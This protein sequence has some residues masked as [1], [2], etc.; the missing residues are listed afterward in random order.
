MSPRTVTIVLP[1][2][3]NDAEEFASDCGFQLASVERVVAAAETVLKTFETDE[4]QGFR[5]RDRQY[6]I[7]I[8]RAALSPS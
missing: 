8:L 7:T 1:E 6:A 3:Y 5:S 2:G 4:A